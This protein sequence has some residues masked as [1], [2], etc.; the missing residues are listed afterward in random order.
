MK[1]Q[2]LHNPELLPYEESVMSPA[3]GSKVIQ[4]PHWCSDGFLG[5]RAPSSPISGEL[6]QSPANP[7]L[8][9]LNGKPLI[10]SRGHVLSSE[11]E[12]LAEQ[13]REPVLMIVRYIW[14]CGHVAHHCSIFNLIEYLNFLNRN[15][16]TDFSSI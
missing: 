10:L 6:W 9:R 11:A 13:Y 7:T 16:I 14:V 12:V 4:A 5:S 2:Q 15:Q 8:G 1:V 3:V